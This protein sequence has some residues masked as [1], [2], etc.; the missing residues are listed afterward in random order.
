MA[1]PRIRESLDGSES[2]F[3][4]IDHAFADESALSVGGLGGNAQDASA[5]PGQTSAAIRA[6]CQ[7][8][9]FLEVLYAA[10]V[11]S[12]AVLVP[13]KIPFLRS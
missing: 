11:T 8:K 7:S 12:D 1:N 5:A 13:P 9:V 6:Y 3:S 4:L 10:Q 2:N